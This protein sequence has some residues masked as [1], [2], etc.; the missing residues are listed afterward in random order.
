MMSGLGFG[1]SS[2]DQQSPGL[3]NQSQLANQTSQSDLNTIKA[4]W[5]VLKEEMDSMLIYGGSQEAWQQ[6]KEQ[7]REMM[8]NLSKAKKYN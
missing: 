7:V 6:K 8:V 5:V 3:G 2:S 4:T 1:S